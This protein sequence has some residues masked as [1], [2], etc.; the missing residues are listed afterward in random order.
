MEEPAEW[1]ISI[2]YD[3]GLNIF[4][5]LFRKADATAFHMLRDKIWQSLKLNGGISVLQ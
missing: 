4:K 1:V 3:P 2:D 5:C